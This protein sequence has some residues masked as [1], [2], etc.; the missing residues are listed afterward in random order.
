MTSERTS[1]VPLTSISH[2]FLQ[3]LFSSPSLL[4]RNY[5]MIQDYYVSMN[6]CLVMKSI[7]Y[8]HHSSLVIL[9]SRFSLVIMGYLRLTIL[10]HLETQALHKWHDIC[11]K[12]GSNKSR[13]NKTKKL[14]PQHKLCKYAKSLANGNQ[15]N[16]LVSKSY[17]Q[18][19]K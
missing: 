8:S 3:C 14:A 9:L 15:S 6:L 7:V 10:R 4:M 12:I 2:N 11:K 1:T 18:Y 16:S 13:H 19:C 17:K 5:Y